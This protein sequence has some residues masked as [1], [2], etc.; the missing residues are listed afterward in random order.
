MG[1]RPTTAVGM[2]L[3]SYTVTHDAGFAPN[4]LWGY[5]T[6]ACCKPVI[7][8]TARQGDWIAGL[9]RASEGKKILYAM[10]VTELPIAYADY[11][12]DPRFQSKIPTYQIRGAIHRCGDN[13]YRPLANGTYKQLKSR[14]SNPDGSENERLKRRDLSGRFVLISSEFW[15]FGR[16][17]LDLPIELRS[18]AVDRGHRC[19]FDLALV[20]AF[21]RWI[22]KQRSGIYGLPHMWPAGDSSADALVGRC[23]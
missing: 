20:D 17:A 5:C 7:R 19:K 8:R 6:L 18:L 11:F 14:H 15:Y 4:P 9:T 12:V 22:R 10:R 23:G 3:Y 13:I 16:E 1:R 2:R 21:V